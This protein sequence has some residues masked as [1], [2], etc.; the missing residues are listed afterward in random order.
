MRDKE[1]QLKNALAYYEAGRSEEAVALCGALLREN[2]EEMDV[3][4]ILAMI[5]SDGLRTEEVAIE[6]ALALN[7]AGNYS[8]ATKVLGGLLD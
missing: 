2:P 4:E 7:R 3:L 6:K 5:K 1:I 8:E